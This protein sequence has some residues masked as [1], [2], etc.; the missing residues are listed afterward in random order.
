MKIGL[1]DVEC[2]AEE[3]LEVV[4]D[5]MRVLAAITFIT[6]AVY[7]LLVVRPI[8]IDLLYLNVREK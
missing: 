5:L 8:D 7:M 3:N 6:N 4:W 2:D 1:E